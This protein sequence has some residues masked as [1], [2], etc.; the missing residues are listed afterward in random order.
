MAD[1]T[2]GQHQTS[3][4]VVV[5]VVFCDVD[6]V[7]KGDDRSTRADIVAGLQFGQFILCLGR[8]K[9]YVVRLQG[10]RDERGTALQFTVAGLVMVVVDPKE[11]RCARTIFVLLLLV[12]VVICE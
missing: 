4:S 9:L 3:K 1:R 2:S 6:V 8:Q 7:K 11:E 5:V 12:V 10:G